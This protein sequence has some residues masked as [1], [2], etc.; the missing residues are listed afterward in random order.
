MQ[1]GVLRHQR[2]DEERR[3]LGIETGTQPVRAISI[4]C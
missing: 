3:A 4:V 1:L 2:L